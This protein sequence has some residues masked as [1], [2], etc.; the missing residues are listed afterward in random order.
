MTRNLMPTVRYAL[1]WVSWGVQWLVIGPLATLALA[2]VVLVWHGGDTPGPALVQYA[3]SVS[4]SSAS[5][6]WF[7]AQ[8]APRE[9]P[10]PTAPCPQVK[11]DVAGYAAYIDR[12]LA[13]LL[14]IFCLTFA[15]L[16][17]S[18][19]WMTGAVPA[20]GNRQV[21]ED[22]RSA[23]FRHGRSANDLAENKDK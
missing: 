22:C 2:V 16:Y 3:E 6:V 11:T 13:R 23:Q 19:A 1:R 12:T 9:I 4:T 7:Y 18:F 10:A 8:C 17:A 15:E 14:R 21:L 5:G 20:R